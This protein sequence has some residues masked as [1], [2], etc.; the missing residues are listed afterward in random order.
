MGNLAF[1]ASRNPSGSR[2][3]GSFHHQRRDRMKVQYVANDGKVFD[4]DDECEKYEDAL[5]DAALKGTT[6]TFEEVCKFLNDRYNMS[7]KTERTAFKFCIE[8]YLDR[9]DTDFV[10]QEKKAP[11]KAKKKW[12]ED[13]EDD[14]EDEDEG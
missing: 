8:K 5:R 7:G 11:M 1:V 10:A 3:C 13:E 9:K 12:D 6:F 4:D 14:F 2:F